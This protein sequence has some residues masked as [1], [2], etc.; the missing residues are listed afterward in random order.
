[1]LPPK[2]LNY[3]GGKFA[4]V[5]RY[6]LA[7]LFILSGASKAVDPYG[8]SIKIGEY[9]GAFGLDVLQPLSGIGGI[10]LP[11]VE[12]MLGLMLLAGLSHKLSSWLA[13]LSMSFFTLLT[14]WLAIANPISD[15]GCFGDMIHLSNWETF[16][17][18]ILFLP[19]GIAMFFSRNR[20]NS[21]APSKIRSI[22]T[23]S[24]LAPLS[25]AISLYS[26]TYLPP[27]D[28]TPF[29]IGVN[30]PTAMTAPSDNL[31]T[32]LIYRDKQDNT[33]HDFAIDDT[34][35]YNSDRWEYVDTRTLGTA[36][37][38]S[39][40]S[41]PMFDGDT[42]RSYEI[43]SHPGYT[44]LY[45]F[46][47]FNPEYTTQI[48]H[49]AD[50][51]SQHSGRVVALSSTPIP[52]SEALHQT[53]IETFSSDNTILRTMVQ[54]SVGG[55]LLLHNGTIIGK[56]PINA[57]PKWTTGDPIAN[58]LT[59]IELHREEMLGVVFALAIALIVLAT[60]LRSVRK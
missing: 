33:L 23:Y 24:L 2:L 5:A 11:S 56:W 32:I 22:I 21:N 43:I 16:W 55:A 35:W 46:N 7:G 30:I 41:L 14:L 54:H 9:L 25:I 37:G 40:K 4:T 51:I 6:H 29:R 45:V 44:L 58:Q 59:A 17:K 8:L 42:D 48:E 38:A 36:T 18:N 50:Y 52:G 20:I 47:N 26:Y 19:F 10:L 13:F 27:I 1:M 34:T 53:G 3:L 15:C 57:L 39:I 31:E 60:H 49:F 12:L 28:P